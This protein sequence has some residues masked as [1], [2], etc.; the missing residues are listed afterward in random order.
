MP[1]ARVRISAQ[2]SASQSASL[3]AATMP[4]SAPMSLMLS[5]SAAAS[6]RGQVVEQAVDEQ[7][8]GLVHGGGGQPGAAGDGIGRGPQRHV[9]PRASA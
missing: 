9:G 8:F 5:A 2:V 3:P 4:V 6:S 1:S 7:Q